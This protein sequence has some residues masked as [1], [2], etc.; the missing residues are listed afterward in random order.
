MPQLK[1]YTLRKL[2]QPSKAQWK[3]RWFFFYM[4]YY[5]IYWIYIHLIHISIFGIHT[6]VAAP[7]HGKKSNFYIAS[8]QRMKST[9][10]LLSIP[11]CQFHFFIRTMK[12]IDVSIDIGLSFALN[13]FTIANMLSTRKKR[14]KKNIFMK[15]STVWIQFKGESNKYWCSRF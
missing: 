15:E 13:Q 7:N 4:I 8:W 11:V 9:L 2:M 14:W 12:N 6:V 10:Y 5:Y 1:R 3:F